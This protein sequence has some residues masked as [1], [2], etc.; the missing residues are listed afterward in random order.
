MSAPREATRR[1]TIVEV[2]D[3]GKM[4][5]KVYTDDE[6]QWKWGA[7]SGIL[8]VVSRNERVEVGYTSKFPYKYLIEKI[9]DEGAEAK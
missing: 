7:H 8:F 3:D 6:Y 9:G 4:S 1:L 2:G 5:T